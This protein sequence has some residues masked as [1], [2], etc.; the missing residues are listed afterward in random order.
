MDRT[1][2]RRQWLKT[3][4]AAAAGLAVGFPLSGCRPQTPNSREAS[5][6]GR[7]IRLHLNESPYGL[8]PSARKAG[9]EA[10][11]LAHQYPHKRYI[12]LKQLIASS[13]NLPPDHVILGAG[14]TEIMTTLIHLHAAGK[15]AVAA[16]PTY[17][18]FIDYAERVD[19]RLRRVPLDA[20]FAHDLQAMAEE[21]NA[22]TGLVY[23]C[24]PN[25]PTGS[26]TPAD[27]LSAFIDRA[28]E[29][30]LVIVDEAYHEYVEEASYR[31]MVDHIRKKKNVIVM[32]TFS[33][34]Y[35]LAGMR[36]GYGLARP[37]IIEGMER[38]ERNFASIAYPSLMASQ[39][40]YRDRSFTAQVKTMN[41]E[42][43]TYLCRELDKRGL[44]FVP[45]Q[46]NFV[47]FKIDSDGEEAVKMF[48]EQGLLLRSLKFNGG[49]WLRV[50][51][52]EM[53][54]MRTLVSLL[55]GIL[56]PLSHSA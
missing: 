37:D 22:E 17:Y 20:E 51:L 25:N 42:T 32:R 56:G 8:S 40:A 30:S 41:R 12:E 10:L 9:T 6:A 50:S 23:I 16:L 46:T 35:G 52:G 28:S 54:D 24:N 14:S 49:D 39:A 13:E 18:D 5:Q 29:K 43:R 53:K 34:I 55:S 21:L 44:F 36:I 31:S 11:E 45:S 2:N 48:E 1:I 26:L 47:L 4:A 7:L 19:C 27:R 15:E 38:L 3:S 33:K